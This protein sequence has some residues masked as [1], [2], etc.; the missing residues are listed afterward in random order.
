MAEER[1]FKRKIFGGFDRNDVMDYV[2]KLMSQLEAARKENLRKDARISEL[3]RKLDEY[4]AAEVIMQ[5]NQIIDSDDPE[6]VLS[7]VDRILQNY[8]SKEESAD[9]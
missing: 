5:E 3:E 6:E 9:G 8:L 2:D 1:L 4:E 7:Q